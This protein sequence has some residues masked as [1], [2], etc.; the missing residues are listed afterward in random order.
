[1]PAHADWS[2]VGPTAAGEMF[3]D[4]ASRERQGD[5][6]RVRVMANFDQPRAEQGGAK[7]RSSSS[8]QEFDC[9]GRRLHLLS[10]Q[11]HDA[12][13]AQGASRVTRMPAPDPWKAV[14]AGTRAEGMLALACADQPLLDAPT[15]DW[16]RQPLVTGSQTLRHDPTHTRRDG[17]LLSLRWLMQSPPADAHPPASHAAQSTEVETTLSCS[18]QVALASTGAGRAAREG[19]GAAVVIAVITSESALADTLPPELEVVARKLCAAQ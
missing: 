14:P 5:L 3:V 6:G 4:L 11:T 13:F 19:Q 2:Y 15:R 1:M 18:R 8:V 17:D 12:A 7:Y 9:S 16:P 10:R